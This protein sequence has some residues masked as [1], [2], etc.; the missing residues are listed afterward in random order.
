MS[1]FKLLLLVTATFIAVLIALVFL[2]RIS[3]EISPKFSRSSDEDEIYQPNE[4]KQRMQFDDFLKGKFRYKE[5]RPYWFSGNEYIT[6]KS[7]GTVVKVDIENGSERI[8]MQAEHLPDSYD[9]WDVSADES[10]LVVGTKW[11]NGYAHYNDTF[12]MTFYEVSTGVNITQPN[13]PSNGI[14]NFKWSSKGHNF[15]FVYSYN[16]YLAADPFVKNATQIT[17][18]GNEYSMFNGIS[19]EMLRVEIAGN[20]I[21]MWWSDDGTY[22]AYATVNDTGV[23]QLEFAMYKELQY[24]EIIKM[25]YSK[26]GTKIPTITLSV[27]DVDTKDVITIKPNISPNWNTGYYLNSVAWRKNTLLPS[28]KN[29]IENE[30]ITEYCRAP[31]F[32]C[33][34]GTIME[35]SSSTGWLGHYKPAY[36]YPL[37]SSNEYMTVQSHEKYPHVVVVN[38]DKNTSDWRTFGEFEVTDTSYGYFA[39][40]HYDETFDWIYFTSTEAEDNPGK[41]LPRN[42]HMWRVKGH[43]KD[44][45]RTCMTCQLNVQYKDRCNWVTPSFS[46]GGRF[47]VVNC[48]GTAN[49][50]PL[51]TLHKRNDVGDFEFVRIVENN[52]KLQDVLGEYQFRTRKYGTIQLPDVE[53]EWYY[54]LHLPP[55]FD[56]LKKYPMLVEVYS[57]PSYQEVKERFVVQWKDYVSSSLDVVVMTFD[58]RGTGFRGDEIMHM[59][60]KKLGQYEPI[61]QIAAARIVSDRYSYIDKSRIAIWGWSYGGYTTTR[62]IGE[63]SQNVFKCG[64]AVAPVTRWELYHAIYT[65]RY[66]QL[67]EDNED[68]YKKGSA[69]QNSENFAKHRYS[70][71]HG[72]K[73]ENVHFQHSSQLSKY[74]IQNDVEFGAFFAADDDHHMHEISNEYKNL[75]RMI[76]KQMKVCFNMS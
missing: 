70:L 14:Q 11:V 73:D 18:D 22:L 12:S 30:M 74:L 47:V 60:Y 41:G 75:M 39:V 1:K 28:W 50:V 35:T 69:L 55:N 27:V 76:T 59:V 10:Y 58:G 17:S 6:L 37:Y 5:L 3:D 53:G 49:G 4:S 34:H 72:T 45:T 19:D 25:P 46:Y 40:Y 7:N 63:D 2:S 57:G 68:G 16:V 29:R 38:M 32:R 56:P 51:S 15:A 62:V 26:P 52:T 67:P 42:R 44:R 43:G 13:L 48:G 9:W 24:P 61:D 21:L 54:T 31:S 66:M 23:S 36:I 65:E 33:F 20:D 8:F 71:F 64:F